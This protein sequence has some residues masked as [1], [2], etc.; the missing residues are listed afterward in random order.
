MRRMR[1][2]IG[3][4][5]LSAGGPLPTRLNVQHI[6]NGRARFRGDQP[7]ILRM[8]RDRALALGREKPFGVELLFE[9]LERLLKRAY[10]LQLHGQDAQLILTALFVNGERT[11][12]HDL[13]A[14]GEEVAIGQQFP[15]KQHTSELRVGIFEGEINMPRTLCF[16]I[17]QLARNP[18]L[19][20]LFFQQ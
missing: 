20:E 7:D 15:A 16:D 5:V 3:L 6:S 13:L 1:S 10:S 12:E 14:I 4:Q 9:P 8:P 11:M 19:T 17:A 2:A 18:N